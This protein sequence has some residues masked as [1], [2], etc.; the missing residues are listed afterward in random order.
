MVWDALLADR[1]IPAEATVNSAGD[2]SAARV[3][4]PVGPAPHRPRAGAE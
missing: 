1:P 2:K 4:R 3:H